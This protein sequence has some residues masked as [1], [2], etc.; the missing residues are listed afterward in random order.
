MKSIHKH[1]WVLLIAIFIAA[2]VGA[3]LLSLLFSDANLRIQNVKAGDILI[4]D[5]S[6]E[7][8]RS[9]INEYYDNLSKKGGLEIEVDGILFG[10]PYSD[11]D[12]NFDID[13]TMENLISRLPRNK[14]EQYFQDF[15]NGESVTPYFTYN[16]GKLAQR[17]EELFSHYE[18][19][20][21]SES[22]RIE[23]G[24]LNILPLSAGIDIDYKVLVQNLGGK[25]LSHEAS[26]KINTNNSPIFLKIFGNSAY[27]Q[28]FDTVSSKASVEY[29]SNVREKTA[30][31]LEIIDNV[32]ID[33]GMD[34]TLSSLIDFY[35]FEN[36]ME[37]DLLNRFASALYQAVL[38][39]N[40]VEV[41]NRRPAKRPVSYAEPGLEAVIEGEDPDLVLRNETGS[42]FL[43]LTELFDKE[44]QIYIV[45]P[46]VINKGT[47]V[48]EEGDE[49]PPPI[50][51]IV[52][53]SLSSNETRLVSQGVSGL[54]V[55][56]IRVVDGKE[57]IISQDKYL[58][59][60]KVVET[61]EK[62]TNTGSK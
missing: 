11:I 19:E 55:T 35:Q 41:L 43:L 59:I 50:I 62:P 30:N 5:A 21:V 17:C 18:I 37:R 16:S 6:I 14:M 7:E 48:V 42:A 10:I 9:I 38:P 24:S 25:I 39:L 34:I 45:S 22:Y 31:T 12:V 4:N 28:V 57:Q 13:K 1:T 46:G 3:G 26:I 49:T 2:G 29:I 58:P 23:N 40:G 32:L 47:I 56:V 44:F 8:T 27:E 53:E 52:N 20:P 61:G 54:T 36:D 15:L 60:S 33:E 51:T